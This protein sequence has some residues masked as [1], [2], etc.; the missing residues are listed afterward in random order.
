MVAFSSVYL[1]KHPTEKFDLG[2]LDHDHVVQQPQWPHSMANINLYK[3]HT[4]IFFNIYHRF[5]DIHISQFV[6]LKI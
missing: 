5:R 3:N 1:S 2:N 6:T 4:S